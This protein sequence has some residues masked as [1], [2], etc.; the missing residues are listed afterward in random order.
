MAL[1][2]SVARSA[3]G[4]LEL[5]NAAARKA[6]IGANLQKKRDDLADVERLAQL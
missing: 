2:M 5:A 4:V 1:E 3:A 6:E